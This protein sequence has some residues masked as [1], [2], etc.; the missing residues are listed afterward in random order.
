MALIRIEA[1][2]GPRR[3]EPTE[4]GEGTGG[5]KHTRLNRELAQEKFLKLRGDGA[6]VEEA[7]R[8]IGYAASTYEKWR[9]RYPEFKAAA[10][11]VTGRLRRDRAEGRRE[12]PDFPEFCK[13][14]LGWELHWHQLQWFDLLEGR[15]PRDLHEAQIYNPGRMTHLI[16]NTPPEHAKTSTVTIAWTLWKIVKDPEQLITIVSKNR[17]MAGDFLSGIKEFLTNPTYA[18]L[19]DDFG[20]EEGYEKACTEWSQYRIRFGP[21]MRKQLAKDPTVQAVGMRGQIYG[22]RA[23]V[24]ILDDC[25]DTENYLEVDKQFNWITRMVSTRA[26]ATGKVLVIGSRVAQVDLYKELRNPDRYAPGVKPAWTYFA[27]PAVLEFAEDP[28]D[29]VTVWPRSNMPQVGDETPAF[30]D[31]TFVMWDGPRLSDRRDVVGEAAWIQGYQQGDLEDSA[32]FP[33]ELIKA[34][35]NKN[36]R[37]GP[38]QTSMAEAALGRPTMDDL[39]VI[40]GMDPAS[41][42]YTAFT[43]YGIH[44]KERKRYLLDVVNQSRMTPGQVRAVI[45]PFTKLYKIKEWRVEAVLLSNW[46]M[47]DTEIVTDLANEGCILAP[48][49]TSGKNKWD[50][51]AGVMGMAGLFAKDNAQIELPNPKH[52]EAIRQFIEQAATFFPETKAPTDILM[53]W[54]FAEIRARDLIRAYRGEENT[55]HVPTWWDSGL[56]DQAKQSMHLSVDSQVD[57]VDSWWG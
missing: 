3:K 26:G 57:L 53:S 56:H 38:L 33:R 17:E 36:R 25:I 2:K 40:G 28:K 5:R 7:C 23:T 45:I 46:I 20:P 34:A 51:I 15:D 12:V 1:E 41:T 22:K 19:Q 24:F 14:Y 13:E 43:V 39:Y 42:G 27:Q 11:R 4:N 8:R 16:V 49:Q 52:S 30:D 50:P 9:D 32:I 44:L 6:T 10:D 37:N 21:K 29:W 55:G 18:K 47:Q 31:G 54:W 35:V 48:H